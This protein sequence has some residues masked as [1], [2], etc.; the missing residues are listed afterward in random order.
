M[1]VMVWLTY[2]VFVFYLN[3]FGVV[4]FLMVST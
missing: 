3:L 4:F 2:E 1:P